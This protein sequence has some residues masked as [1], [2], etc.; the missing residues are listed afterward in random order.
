MRRKVRRKKLTVRSGRL[1]LGQIE[2]VGKIFAWKSKRGDSGVTDS[3]RNAKSRIEKDMGM[4]P[5]Q[6]DI[7]VHRG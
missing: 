6:Y 1:I 3:L 7:K 4:S 5:R 2:K